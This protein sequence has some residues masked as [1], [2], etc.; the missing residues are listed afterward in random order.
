MRRRHPLLAAFLTGTALGWGGARL[1]ADPIALPP[2]RV[3]RDWSLR[4][5][6]V[7]EVARRVRDCV[8]NI[9]SERT[10]MGGAASED[11]LALDR[12]QHRINGMGTGIVIDPRGYVVTNHHVID[13]VNTLRVRLSD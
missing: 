5:T 10:V 4:Q 13:E 9:H 2:A 1:H 6:P 8:V 11:L 12:T 3:T 7:V